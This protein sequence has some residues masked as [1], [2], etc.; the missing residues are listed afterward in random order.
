MGAAMN[1]IALHGGMIPFGGTFLIFADYMRPSIRLAAL[2][3]Q[4]VV[5]V[6][7]HDSIGLGEDG[8]THQP[9][10]HLSALRAI[11][12]LIV[13]RPADAN[14]V[15]EAWRFALKHRDGPVAL[16]LTRQKLPLIDRALFGS[17]AGVAQGAYVV[18]DAVSGPPQV[19]LIGSGSELQLALGA[20]ESL[21]AHH[22]RARVVS[23]PSHELFAA[24]D[25]R[26]RDE[27]LLPGVPRVAVEAAHSMSW[28][29]WV[30][31]RGAIVGLDHFGASAPAPE[32]FRQF[33]LTV[34]HVVDAAL[35]VANK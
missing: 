19:V 16:A 32:L 28:H 8:P 29:R 7:T 20:R 9:V 22:V 1:G 15:T 34:R 4:R 17:A 21:A 31:E 26:Y 11:P 3:R 14:E 33:G 25:Q 6:F 23:M 27:V 2:M 12:G 13:L 24:Q 5:Y 18:A 10:E 35:G 30:G